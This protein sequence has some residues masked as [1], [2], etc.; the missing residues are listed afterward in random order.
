MLRAVLFDL[1]D[2]LFDHRICARTALTTLHERFENGEARF[3][4]GGLARGHAL[5][6]ITTS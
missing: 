6:V 1:D 2:T 5:F 3:A 4:A